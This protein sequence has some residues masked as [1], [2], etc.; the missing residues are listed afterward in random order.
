MKTAAPHLLNGLAW[1][2]QVA[3]LP[4]LAVGFVATPILWCARWCQERAREWNPRLWDRG[5]HT[6]LHPPPGA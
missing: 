4:F 2:L 1:L 3:A 5:Q 6:D